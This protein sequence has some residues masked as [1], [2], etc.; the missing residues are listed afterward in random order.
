MCSDKIANGQCHKDSYDLGHPTTCKE[1][2]RYEHC[3]RKNCRFLHPS[4]KM[5][6]GDNRK[7][8]P[9]RYNNYHYKNLSCHYRQKKTIITQEQ[10][11]IQT[12]PLWSHAK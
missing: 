2:V 1:I 9:I 6:K 4:N 3:N 8:Y 10:L 5:N 12:K 11:I 7:K